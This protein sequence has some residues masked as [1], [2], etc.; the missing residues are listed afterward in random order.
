MLLVSCLKI[1]CHSDDESM[2]A[3][4]GNLAGTPAKLSKHYNGLIAMFESGLHSTHGRGISGV[5]RHGNKVAEFL[6]VVDGS[7]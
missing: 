2:W 7:S 3:V 4:S 6:E 5:V 1:T